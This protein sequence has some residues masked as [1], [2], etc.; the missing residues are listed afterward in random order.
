[1]ELS[2]EK[3]SRAP[4]AVKL[5]VIYCVQECAEFVVYLCGVRINSAFGLCAWSEGDWSSI[6][7]VVVFWLGWING[8]Y[9]EWSGVEIIPE[10][11]C[12][13]FVKIMRS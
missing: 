11:Y 4:A 2:L 5:A 9:S 13:I 6:V 12:N 1:M 10:N 8:Y 3:G 7:Q